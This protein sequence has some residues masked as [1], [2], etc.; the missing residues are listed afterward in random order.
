[1]KHIYFSSISAYQIVILI[2][3]LFISEIT[4]LILE[5]IMFI[6]YNKQ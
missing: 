6:P 2:T 4:N 1:M 5:I 3:R